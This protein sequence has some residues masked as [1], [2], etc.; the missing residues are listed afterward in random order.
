MAKGLIGKKIGCT[1][2]WDADQYMMVT[3]I[4]RV[5][6]VIIEQKDTA[7]HGYAAI[8]VGYEPV[9]ADRLTRPLSGIYAKSEVATHRYMMEFRDMSGDVGTSLEVT[10]FEAG[11]KVD[12]IGTSRGLGF[13]GVMKRH[14][15]HGDWD[16]H[17]A[18]SHRRSGS[19][20]CR[21]TPGHVIKGMRMPGRMGGDRV[22][23][24]GLKV[25]KIIEDKNLILVKGAVPG[26]KGAYVVVNGK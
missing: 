1:Q 22:T 2:L 6:N 11:E 17:G 7:K 14:H 24:K 21:L 10:Q 23:Q 16:S 18:M 3:V 25:V 26:P 13:A 4:E 12:V 19:I 20:G 9:T 15:F 5:P 8:K